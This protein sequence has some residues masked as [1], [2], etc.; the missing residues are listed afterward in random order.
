VGYKVHF[1][2][3]CDPDSPHSITQV[4]TTPATTADAAVSPAIHA[5]PQAKKLLTQKHLVDT[6]YLDAELLVSSREEYEVD[7]VGPTRPRE[8]TEDLARKHAA[9]AG[10]EETLSPG[11]RVCE[12]RRC[13]YVGQAKSHRQHV[14]T[15]ASLNF[16]RVGQ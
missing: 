14:F 9:R 3:T 5:A 8:S 6:G 2:E 11:I 1:A 16:L 7:L 4:Q 10:V 12:M 15:T 13:R